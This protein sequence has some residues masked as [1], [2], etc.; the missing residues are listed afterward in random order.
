MIL[1]LFHEWESVA[2][3]INLCQQILCDNIGCQNFGLAVREFNLMSSAVKRHIVISCSNGCVICIDSSFLDF[4]LSETMFFEVDPNFHVQQI[5]RAKFDGF[6]HQFIW[7]DHS[8]EALDEL[9]IL[10]FEGKDILFVRWW[11]L[12]C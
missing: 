9:F 5:V 4:A 1:N 8:V 10:I 11:Q 12:H 3:R 7:L 2:F 6:I